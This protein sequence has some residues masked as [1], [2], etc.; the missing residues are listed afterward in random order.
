MKDVNMQHHRDTHDHVLP[1]WEC[2]KK[3]KTVEELKIHFAKL[4]F[5]K[6]SE[7]DYI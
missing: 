5:N 1:C 3:L 6:I 4:H 7:I 2:N